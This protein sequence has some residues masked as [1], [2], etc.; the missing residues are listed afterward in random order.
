MAESTSLQLEQKFEFK[1]KPARGPAEGSKGKKGKSAKYFRFNQNQN[2]TVA[3]H[4]RDGEHVS[5]WD[6]L[7]DHD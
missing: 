2:Q 1:D 4:P 7:P 3:H 5:G 6:K